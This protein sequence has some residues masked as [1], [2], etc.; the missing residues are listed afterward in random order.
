MKK[1]TLFYQIVHLVTRRKTVFFFINFAVTKKVRKGAQN[2]HRRENNDK[3]T[4]NHPVYKKITRHA[5][6]Q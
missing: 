5:L 1:G 3:G 4:L 2:K 6:C